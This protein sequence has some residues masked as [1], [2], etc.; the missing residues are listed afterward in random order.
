VKVDA[1]LLGPLPVRRDALV[2]VRLVDN[3]G[4]QLRAVAACVRVGGRKLSAEDGIFAASRNQ[5]SQ[6]CPDTVHS[7]AEHD[8]GDEYEYG[9][10]SPHGCGGGVGVAPRGSPSPSPF[11]SVTGRAPG[12]RKCE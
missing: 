8:D 5:Q 10:A 2:D 4:D 12:V 3:L 1:G 9:D 7:E 6:Q 11:P